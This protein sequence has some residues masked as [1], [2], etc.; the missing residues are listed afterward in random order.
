M[1]EV[2]TGSNDALGPACEFGVYRLEADGRLFRGQTPIPLPPSELIALRMLLDH[3]GQIVT[4]VQLRRAIWGDRK[5]PA[6]RLP[7]CI[8]SLH[9]RI[10]PHIS[11]ETVYKRGYRIESEARPLATANS[12]PRLAILPFAAEFGVP[13]YLGPALAEE[14][15]AQLMRARHL[16]AVVA[17]QDSVSTLAGCRLTPQQ[18]GSVLA[19]DLVLRGTLHA[20]PAHYRLAAVMIRVSDGIEL[21]MEDML[22][23]RTRLAMLQ[24]EL[25][26]RVMIRMQDGGLSI[27]AEEPPDE[28]QDDP[29]RREAWETYLQAH[30]EWQSFE[31][32]QMQD[33]MGRLSRAIELD[34]LLMDARVDMVNLCVHQCI[35]GFMS[36][37][38]AAGMVKQAAASIPDAAAGADAILPML[39]VISFHVDRD[40]PAALRAFSLSAHLPHNPFVTRARSMFALSRHRTDEAI[41]IMRAA[42]QLDPWSPMLHSRLAWAFHLSGQ[43]LE[44]V[45]HIEESLLRFPANQSVQLHAAAILA[46]CGEAKRAVHLTQELA[47]QIPYSDIVTATLAYALAIDDRTDEARHHLEQQLWLNRERFVLRSS[48]VPVYV[49]L[50]EYDAALRELRS[51]DEARCPWFFQMLIDPRLRP[52][53]GYAEFKAMQKILD[54]MEAS[55]AGDAQ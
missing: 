46:H 35:F 2:T 38:I 12:L 22:V 54:E 20:L 31:R 26:D 11:I 34:P 8:A 4:P 52:L 55:A 29:L 25:A 39:G 5:V 28:P 9:A 3:A 53:H 19:C 27:S 37:A 51:A 6:G 44:S 17:A 24:R 10:Q 21:W 45:R 15:G 32:H 42:I 14:T 1:N 18:V 23:E 16:V 36:P 13:E 33:A 41:E 40:L 30:Q 49:A 47:R 7:A 48:L 43:P 50:G